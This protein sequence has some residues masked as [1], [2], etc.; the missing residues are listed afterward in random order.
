VKPF[1]SSASTHTLSGLGGLDGRPLR[2]GDTLT[3]ASATASFRKRTLAPHVLERL[4]LAKSCASPQ[5]HRV[6]GFQSLRETCFIRARIA[7]L[8][9]PTAWVFDW[10]ARHCR[11]L[12]RAHDYRG[13]FARRH[14]DPGRR[15][16]IILFVEQ[17]TTGGYPKIANVI[18]A[19][20]AGVGQLRPRDEIRFER[21]GWEQARSLLREQEKLLAGEESILG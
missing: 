8:R 12:R 21:I 19:D 7:L 9:N 2:K 13:R 10:K 5:V 15:P 6:T 16:A 17:Q 3:V 18:S 14:S 20:L 11:V 4:S 1:L